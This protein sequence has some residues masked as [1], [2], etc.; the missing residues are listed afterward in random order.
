MKK[1]NDT[2]TEITSISEFTGHEHV[3]IRASSV[4][5]EHALTVKQ[6]GHIQE[7]GQF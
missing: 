2:L 1:E 5:G 7:S 3:I 4:R 6:V